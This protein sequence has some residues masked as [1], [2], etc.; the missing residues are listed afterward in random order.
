MRGCAACLMVWCGFIGLF[1][2]LRSNPLRIYLEYNSGVELEKKHDYLSAL[3]SFDEAL[4]SLEKIKKSYP[5]WQPDLVARKMADCHREIA[6]VRPLA[7]NE[8]LRDRATLNSILLIPSAP[9]QQAFNL[10]KPGSYEAALNLYEVILVR[11]EIWRRAEPSYK[12]VQEQNGMA[13]C[14][15]GIIRSETAVEAEDTQRH[16]KTTI[17]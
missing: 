14:R 12:P 9:I 7:T 6:E 3:A 15:E 4:S 16:G 5:T 1:L 17:Q 10:E 11:L 2:P 8:V 13:L